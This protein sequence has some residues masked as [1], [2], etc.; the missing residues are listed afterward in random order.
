MIFV[1]LLLLLLS[2]AVTLRRDK[3]ILYSRITIIILIYSTLIT[4]NNLYFSFLE[5]GI[6]L[7]GG[8]F[9]TTCNTNIFHIF[10][11]LLSSVILNLTAFYPRKVWT[12]EYSS[13][14]KLLFCRLMYY[15]TSILNKM[16]EQYKII[17]YPLILLFIIIGA[18]FLISTSDLVSIFLSIEL[19][20]Y[21]LYLLSTIYRNSES[22]TSGGLM[23][24]LLGGLS[25]CFILLST[26][27]LYANS[28]TTNLD[29]L[30]IITS[31]SDIAQ[32]NSSN[33]LYWY[34]PYYIHISLLIMSVGFLFKVSA[35]PFHFWSPDV[36]D[37]IPTIVTTFVAIIAK[38]SIFIFLLELVHY[39]SKS[40]FDI[41]FSWTTSLLLSSLISL[42]I[43]T[44]VGLTQFRI[45][46]LY[47]YST[48]SHV[49]FILLALS[50]HSIESIQ[51]FIFYIMQYSIS[52][53]NAFILII[54]IGYSL[55]CYIYNDKDN[56]IESNENKDKHDLIDKN[57]SPIQLI[58]QLKGYYYINPLLALSL[59]ITLFSFVGVPPLIGFFAKQMILSAALDNGYIFMTL[60]AILT[61]VIS[62]VYYLAVIKQIFFDKPDYN[63]NPILNDLN[64]SGVIAD[65]N[66]IINKITIK[67]KNIVISS[68][69]TL[70]ISI[71]TLIILLFIF[72]P[73]EWLSMANILALILFNI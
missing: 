24:F 41:S 1:S 59:S 16:G 19:Q 32:Y 65:E 39:T 31:I 36:Y 52:N 34:Q 50:I 48:I 73:Q 71:L 35:A 37:A 51:A 14:Y 28:G 7:F 5:K 30:Y 18:L 25:S 12:K 66:T 26:S 17:E 63:L 45:K 3:S 23:Y 57:N 56:K 40:M 10:I 22:A 11:F 6:G 70:T 61:S 42:I 43:G 58:S 68:S 67:S 29:S 69:L 47:A 15:Q 54:S 27:L 55:Y 62:A 4:Y 38:I 72:I 49:G 44:V 33:I 60:I 53:L 46:R 8:L 21:G 9:H 13:I 20:S 64:L 2:N